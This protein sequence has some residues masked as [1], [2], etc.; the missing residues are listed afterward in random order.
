MRTLSINTDLDEAGSCVVVIDSATEYVVLI[1]S[2]AASQDFVD[3]VGVVLPS[4]ALY[5]LL[6]LMVT[7]FILQ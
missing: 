3:Y 4:G 5:A 7:L 6:A 2:V 1:S